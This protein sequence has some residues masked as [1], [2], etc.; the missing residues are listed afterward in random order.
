MFSDP[1]QEGLPQSQ[2][3]DLRSAAL[4]SVDRGFQ[5]GAS[6]AELS[7]RLE[8]RCVRVTNEA[9]ELIEA[10]ALHEAG[11]RAFR[12]LERDVRF[13]ARGSD[14]SAQRDDPRMVVLLGELE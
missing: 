7:C 13:R 5:G 14:Q 9:F 8:D 12:L 2:V 6:G 10:V 11:D 3:G 1:A 4:Q